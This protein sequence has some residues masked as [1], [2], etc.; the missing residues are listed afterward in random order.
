[1]EELMVL[2]EAEI[3][4]RLVRLDDGV[5]VWHRHPVDED[6]D[7]QV[8]RTDAVL[9]QGTDSRRE[10]RLSVGD[11]VD[12]SA[13]NGTRLY[14]AHGT[15][16]RPTEQERDAPRFTFLVSDAEKA[17]MARVFWSDVAHEELQAE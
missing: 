8:W 15:E 5:V 10:L 14:V 4:T 3:V 2:H 9:I 1:M 11:L 16:V 13:R 7:E 12:V 6:A 17:D